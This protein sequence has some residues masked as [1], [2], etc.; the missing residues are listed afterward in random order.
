MSP[1]AAHA[2][3][4][5]L[6]KANGRRTA[7]TLRFEEVVATAARARDAEEGFAF[8]VG[9]EVDDARQLTTACFAVRLEA[10]VVV[11]IGA[12]RAQAPDPSRAFPELKAW[13]RYN[14]AAN[15]ARAFAWATKAAAGRVRLAVVPRASEARRPVRDGEALL[16]AVLE[17]PDDEAARL[18]YAD[19][20]SERGE[21]RGEL[22]ALGAQRARL[23]PG[24]PRA[25][26]LRERELVLSAQLQSQ[27]GP[28]FS[29][30][31]VRGVLRRGFVEEVSALA[32]TLFTHGAALFV[33][34]PIRKLIV[35]GLREEDAP[36][37]AQKP[38]LER[39]KVLAF[40]SARPSAEA[41]LGPEGLVH[42]LGSRRLRGLEALHFVGQRLGDVG[43]LVLAKN[44][45][46]AAPRLAR[47][48]LAV[49]DLGPLGMRALASTRWLAGLA[50]LKL[51]RNELRAQGVE[52]L[53]LA[54]GAPAWTALE[55][56]GNSLGDE[57]ARALARSPKLS[58]VRRLSLRRNHIG[59]AGARL[60]LDSQGLSQLEALELEGNPLSGPLRAAVAA[61]FPPASEG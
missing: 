54:R 60:L 32:S 20:L 25:A 23:T 35:F 37:F 30:P 26:A 49:D 57:G 44:L 17:R 3:S 43:A 24:D 28:L 4:A 18:V 47:F 40:D 29:V 42:L 11:G 39:L 27:L 31:G 36:R 1:E 15:S 16:R 8:G 21:V 14:P 50:E 46:G 34:E 38:W 41:S 53:L 33:Q 61:R 9:G 19:H 59:T 51:S 2:L 55:L 52:E 7:R 56:D 22:I 5:A 6:T 48:T 45:H 13:D 10:S 12:C 58:G